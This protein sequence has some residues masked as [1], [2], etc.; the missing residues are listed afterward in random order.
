MAQRCATLLDLIVSDGHGWMCG[1]G[2]GGARQVWMVLRQTESIQAMAQ[3][4]P[5]SQECVGRRVHSH[6]HTCFVRDYVHERSQ[7]VVPPHL[8]LVGV[9]DGSDGLQLVGGLGDCLGVPAAAVSDPA[10]AG[11]WMV[12]DSVFVT[13]A[14]CR[15]QR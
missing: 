11:K 15:P 4:R 14:A 5:S 10:R 12:V 8:S 2:C 6:P 13:I 9:D 7:W 3:S 1:D